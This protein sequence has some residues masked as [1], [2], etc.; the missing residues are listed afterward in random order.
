M[1]ECAHRICCAHKSQETHLMR[2]NSVYCPRC[3]QEA[4]EIDMGFSFAVRIVK[5]NGTPRPSVRVAVMDP[6]PIGLGSQSEYTHSDGWTHFEWPDGSSAGLDICVD[7]AD[8]G[9][10]VVHDGDTFSLTVDP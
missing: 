3:T 6:R 1:H 7:G 10:Y 5:S 4:K 8:Q 2:M 9:Y